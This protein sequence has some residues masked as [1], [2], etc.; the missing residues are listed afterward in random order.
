MRHGC[1]KRIQT[2]GGKPYV[3]SGIKNFFAK[4]NVIHNVAAPYHPE[5]NGMGDQLIRSLKDR[6]SHVNEDQGFNLN[7]N[8]NIAVSA[9][10]KVPHRATSFLPIVLLYGCEAITPYEIP[11]TR[12]TLEEQYQDALRSHIKKM[13]KIHQGAFLSK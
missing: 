1:P 2:D 10:Q 11:F 9:Y 4:F 5:S 7:R 8:L 6:L 12:Y 13:F 3:L